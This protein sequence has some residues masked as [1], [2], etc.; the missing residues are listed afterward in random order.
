MLWNYAHF[1]GH[2][3]EDIGKPMKEQ[4]EDLGPIHGFPPYY[5]SGLLFIKRVE[6]IA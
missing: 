3:R 2:M 4:T 1:V 6:S 5:P